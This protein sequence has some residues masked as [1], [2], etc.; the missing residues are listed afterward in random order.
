M[1]RLAKRTLGTFLA[2]LAGLA[3]LAAGALSLACQARQPEPAAR[4]E[5][6]P[7][8][9]AAATHAQTAQSDTRTEL[10]VARA[11]APLE[12]KSGSHL[13]GEAFF[14]KEEGGRIAFGVTVKNVSPGKH[15]VHIHENGDCSAADAASAG[16]HWNPT[17]EEH[18]QWGVEP[19]HLGDIG[20]IEV[21]EDGQG[22][23]T[24]S[25][26][27]W[28]LDE[29]GKRA[30]SVVGKS[31]V[32]HAGADDFTTQPSGASGARIGCGVITWKKE[33]T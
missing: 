11:V 22:T 8:S 12:A 26:D 21:G 16:G 25:T 9:T 5:E 20:N 31:V 30:R 32:V 13:T 14:V 24:L 10:E 1:E 15:A 2:G 4:S 29:D 7:Q 27:L 17:N 28:T 6:A 18:G 3:G 33:E 23:L 19:F